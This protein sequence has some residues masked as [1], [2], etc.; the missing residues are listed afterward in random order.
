[1][2]K[3][4]EVFL[5]AFDQGMVMSKEA[6]REAAVSEDAD[7]DELL[8]NLG[9]VPLGAPVKEFNAATLRADVES[10]LKLLREFAA[11]T[12]PITTDTDP[13]LARLADELA[14][15]AAT[16]AKDGIDDK[17]QRQNRKVLIFSY[18]EDTVD[19]IE[20]FLLARVKTDERLKAY[21]NR[22]ASV[23]GTA[24]R[25]GVNREAATAGFAPLSVT[26]NPDQT[27]KFDILVCTDVLAEGMNLQQCRHIIN[28]DLPWNPMRLVQRHGRIDRIGSPH[29]E[30]FLRTFFPD[31]EL[32]RLLELETRVRR[33]L[34]Q[35]AASVGVEVAP[36]A[37]TEGTDHTFASTRDEIEKLRSGDATLFERG[38]TAG[39]AQTGE[40]YRHEL[41]KALQRAGKRIRTLPW[42]SG[43]GLARGPVRGH[44]FCARVGDRP[45]VRFVPFDGGPVERELAR[46]LRTIECTP[47]TPRVVPDDLLRGAYSAWE[48]ARADIDAHWAT[49][50]DPANLQPRVPPLN[51]ELAQLLRDN[52]PAGVTPDRLAQ[53]IGALDAPLSRREELELRRVS[54]A[55]YTGAR[56]RAAAVAK[57]IDALGLEPFVPP[58]PLPPIAPEEIH[59][60]CWMAVEADG[61]T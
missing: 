24:S 15:I 6:L 3:E 49:L 12:Q 32:N 7:A 51:H 14:E 48:R 54:G 26:G 43:S 5:A 38:G 16:A 27:D 41:R 21:E 56:A 30:V 20:E 40:E 61:R 47:E 35:A 4:H 11:K 50:T 1:M 17:D 33:K 28:Y 9:D 57:V 59:L 55:E 8:D 44:A 22:V 36:L 23:A 31:T 42:R 52:P 18:Y 46:C 34:A 58:A 39:A 13:K 25:N 53:Y 29:K 19:R 60:V 2:A 45:F 37:G 10:D